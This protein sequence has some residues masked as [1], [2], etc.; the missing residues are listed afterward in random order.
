MGKQYLEL[1]PQ[2]IDFIQQQK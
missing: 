1:T 2:H